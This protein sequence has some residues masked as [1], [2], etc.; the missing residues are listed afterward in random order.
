MVTGWVLNGLDLVLRWRRASWSPS[1][2]YS[3]DST[4]RSGGKYRI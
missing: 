3:S 4:R 2:T 1:P